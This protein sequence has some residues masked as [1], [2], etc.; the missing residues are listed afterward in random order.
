LKLSAIEEKP[1][2]K[3]GLAMVDEIARISGNDENPLF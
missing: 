3:S 1:V 2:S